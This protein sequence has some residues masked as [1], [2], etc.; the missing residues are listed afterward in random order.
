[1]SGKRVA[2]Y[3]RVSTQ[4]QSCDLQR[5]ELTSY[6]QAR[7]WADIQIYEDHG[8][9]GTTAKRPMLQKLMADARSRRIDVVLVWK[10]DRFARSLKDLLTMLQEVSELGIAFISLKDQ[11]DMTT[12]AGRLMMQMLGA[13]GEFEASLIRERVRA[14][15]ANAKA[16][17]RHI[18]RPKQRDDAQIAQ[19]RA[20][21]HSMRTIA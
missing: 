10:L 16:K 13:F 20:Q 8:I 18:G 12:A 7:G 3:L 17:G 1:M 11:I 5:R 21:G 6:A 15:L 9:S 2:L 4:D 14:G 19:L